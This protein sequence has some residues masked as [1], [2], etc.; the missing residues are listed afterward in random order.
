MEGTSDPAVENYQTTEVRQRPPAPFRTY[1]TVGCGY[2]LVSE[3][4]PGA[5]HVF[6]VNDWAD[7]SAIY[8]RTGHRLPKGILTR[9]PV[10]AL[11]VDQGHRLQPPSHS[12]PV[13][14]DWEGEV[15]RAKQPPKY[16]VE[17]WISGA[18]LWGAGPLSKATV[19]RWADQG[20]TTRG[21]VVSALKVGGA[22]A[23]SWL[24][25]CR[26]LNTCQGPIWP[27]QD[28]ATTSPRAMSNL[29]TP[30]GL[31]PRARYRKHLP[32]YVP[33]A[34]HPTQ[35]PMPWEDGLKGS[36]W[37]STERGY[38]AI[39]P[40][41]LLN[42]LGKKGVEPKTSLLRRTTSVYL[43]E[44]LGRAL[45]GLEAP[46]RSTV[47]IKGES[48][49]WSARDQLIREAAALPDQPDP[50]PYHWAPPPI[51]EGSRWFWARCSN[52]FRAALRYPG[53]EVELVNRGLRD[54]DIHRGNYDRHGPKPTHLKV[55]W[56]EFPPE[57]WD[58]LREGCPMNFL[59]TPMHKIE[60]NGEMDT[61]QLVVAGQF[62]DELMD[63]HVVGQP[64]PGVVIRATT[65]LFSLPKDGQP[66]QW[67]IIANMKVGGQNEGAV[68]DPVYLNRPMHILEQLYEGGWSAVIDASKFFY[69][70]AVHPDDYQ[71]LGL[72][73]P[74]SGELLCWFS[75]PMGATASPG[76]AGRF[77][78]SLLRALRSRLYKGRVKVRANCWWTSL[79][80]EGY[81]PGLGFGYVLLDQSGKPVTRFFVHVDDFFLHAPTRLQVLVA[82]NAFMELALE[83]GM[84]CHPKKLVPPS[85]VVKYTGFIFDTRGRPTL[86]VPTAKRERALAMVQ[87]LLQKPTHHRWS[88]LALSV[89]TGTL[90]SLADATP[91]RL[92]HTYLRSLYDVIHPEGAAL[93]ASRYYEFS[94]L[95]GQVMS[96]LTWWESILT[97][98]ISRVAYPLRASTLVPTYG[99]GSGTGTGGTI[100]L[101]GTGM[102]MWMGQW[103]PAVSAHTSNWKELK[104]LLLVLQQLHHSPLRE[105]VRDVVLFYFTDNVVTY[106]I[107]ASGSST[108]PALHELIKLAR[109]YEMLLGCRLQVVHIPGKLMIRQGTDG[110]SRGIWGSP[111]HGEV[112][113]GAFTAALFAPAPLVWEQVDHFAAS[114]GLAC[115]R[116]IHSPWSEPLMD[117]DLLHRY[118]VHCPPPELARQTIVFLLEAWV[119]SPMDTGALIFVPRVV[120]A[121]WHGLSRHLTE[122]AI[123]PAPDYSD[124]CATN[125]PIV[126]LALTPFFRPDHR[127]PNGVDSHQRTQPGRRRHRQLADDMRGLQTTH[128]G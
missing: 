45:S 40:D 85:Q 22:I 124:L 97:H 76:Y 13:C 55:L 60:P 44:Y 57:H 34:Y 108:S 2:E 77:G 81:V 10:E 118:T 7:G 8:H 101:P 19:T 84:L 109:N 37:V 75:L 41:E 96:D 83:M 47:R 6:S 46:Q 14:A 26:H 30:P 20:Y 90:E 5:T 125:I 49:A 69:Q 102:T 17:S 67:R 117:S 28:E 9:N 121:F 59:V 74:M 119:E 128:S 71:Y 23:Q 120:P 98:E 31:V 66:N 29:L 65:P 79:K 106:Y 25:V 73:H 112:D 36:H 3:A 18:A 11:V 88:T 100:D 92:G 56:W 99:D 42:G 91:M 116:W 54:L 78:L 61:G 48:L 122:L 89:V 94:T 105:E 70:F 4:W 27:E 16:V 82:L 58:D 107:G 24:L 1:G 63:L 113:Q 53:R 95:T 111:L 15:C 115:K 103:S 62:V 93:G 126:A 33:K 86:R 43:W 104:T 21:T 80:A 87:H 38:R 52:L 123:I 12:N 39:A 110:L 32:D 35:D 114:L 72:T 64:P 68:G 50:E 127:N 51:H